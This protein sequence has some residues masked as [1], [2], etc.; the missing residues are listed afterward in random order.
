MTVSRSS[1]KVHDQVG[2][3]N[4]GSPS[5]KLESLHQILPNVMLTHSGHEEYMHYLIIYTLPLLLGSNG[6][7]TPHLFK[8]KNFALY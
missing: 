7:E 3:L 1:N 5:P 6:N 2:D 4:P 8:F